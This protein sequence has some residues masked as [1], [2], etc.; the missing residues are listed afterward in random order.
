MV[1][2]AAR[3]PPKMR[4]LRSQGSVIPHEQATSAPPTD[5][6]HGR[7]S[8]LIRRGTQ[9]VI[10]QLP[11]VGQASCSAV[12]L[13]GRASRRLAT[14]QWHGARLQGSG[15]PVHH[16][17]AGRAAAKSSSIACRFRRFAVP[18]VASRRS[19]VRLRASAPE[20]ASRPMSSTRTVM[21]LAAR[22][23]RHPPLLGQV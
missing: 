6:E 17:S 9:A 2:H 14:S 11:R 8:F 1:S 3:S 19:V 5:A 18:G 21:P 15:S 16:G 10:G 7:S 12:T 4:I 13:R 20:T 22:K 23:A